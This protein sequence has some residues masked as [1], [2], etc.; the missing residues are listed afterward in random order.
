VEISLDAGSIPAASTHA[1]CKTRLKPK[2]A[3]QLILA[4]LSFL[5]HVSRV[6]GALPKIELE[7]IRDSPAQN[8]P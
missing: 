8:L 7:S 3:R 2:L 5:P 1:G 6:F 4:S